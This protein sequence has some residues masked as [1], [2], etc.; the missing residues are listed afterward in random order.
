[1]VAACLGEVPDEE[2]LEP[3]HLE[4]VLAAAVLVAAL[5]EALEA[6]LEEVE[7][8]ARQIQ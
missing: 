3:V 5:A 7:G 8:V 4:A 1:M 6:A 2:V